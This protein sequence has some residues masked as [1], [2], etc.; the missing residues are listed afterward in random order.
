MPEP[1]AEAVIAKL[2][3]HLGPHVAKMAVRS[4][5]KKAGVDSYEQLTAAHLPRLIEDIRPMLNVMIGKG[6]S[7]SV[8]AD[9]ER[10]GAGR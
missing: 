5:A 2:S 3:G 10:T 8:V 7:E 6:A 4:F 1:I 9:I